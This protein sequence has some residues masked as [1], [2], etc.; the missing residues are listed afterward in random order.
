MVRCE[1]AG[2]RADYEEGVAGEDP[3]GGHLGDCEG[4]GRPSRDR[5][6]IVVAWRRGKGGMKD[7]QDE[8][9]A[10]AE[11]HCKSAVDPK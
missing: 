7:L 6:G 10:T 9:N 11:R 5:L 1:G 8:V 3:D 4:L 2:V